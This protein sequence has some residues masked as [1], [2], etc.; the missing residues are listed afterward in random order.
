MRFKTYQQPKEIG[1]LGWI[2]S[3]TN[4]ILAFVQLNGT[5][6]WDW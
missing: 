5:I 3:G 1:Y 2:E 6:C 4:R